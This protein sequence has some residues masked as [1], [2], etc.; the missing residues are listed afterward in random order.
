MR[1][2]YSSSFVQC[3]TVL[4]PLLFSDKK[5]LGCYFFADDCISHAVGNNSQNHMHS[6]IM[7]YGQLS[8]V[9]IFI[10]YIIV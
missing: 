6:Y 2:Y 1:R 9:S 3:L 7:S 5:R 10:C 8:N 4:F